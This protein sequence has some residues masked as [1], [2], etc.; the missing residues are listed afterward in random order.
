MSLP[1]GIPQIT[2]AEVQTT[3]KGQK[4]IPIA[5]ANNGGDRV[6]IFPGRQD[7]PFN[8]AAYQNPDASRLNLCY[9]PFEDFRAII[10]A[11][12]NQVKEQLTPRLKEIF[13]DGVSELTYNS[14]LK[15][16]RNGYT[17][18]RTKINTEGRGSVRIWNS[19]K[20]LAPAPEDWTAVSVSPRI[21][22]KC[23]YV[24]NKEV[25]L[26]LETSDVCVEPKQ[27]SCPF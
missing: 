23:V 2:L 16:T 17:H 9:T 4:S 10:T 1:I 25:G 7:V 24:M 3:S 5:Y 26:I 22:V 14:P 11:L 27:V 15:D 8:P 6:F 19:R 18:V 12:D 13:G 20:Q 21:W